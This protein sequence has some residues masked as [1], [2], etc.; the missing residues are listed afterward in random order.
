MRVEMLRTKLIACL[1]C[2]SVLVGAIA[3][4]ADP[5]LP[6]SASDDPAGDAALAEQ[7]VQIGQAFLA[8]RAINDAV[9]NEALTLFKIAA[10]LNPNEARYYRLIAEAALQKRD[11]KL[12][13][14][15]LSDY[16]RLVRDD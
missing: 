7:F 5:V 9:W 2:G 13:L 8:T 4:G 1:L 11:T 14:Q 15:A 16:L 3:R 12:A 6:T 10:K